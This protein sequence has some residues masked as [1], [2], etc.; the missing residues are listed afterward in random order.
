M[1]D[2]DQGLEEIT[3]DFF[4]ISADPEG[5]IIDYTA[6]SELAVKI[7]VDLSPNIL[8]KRLDEFMATWGIRSQQLTG[9]ME[10]YR[11]ILRRESTQFKTGGDFSF[12]DTHVHLH[13]F[14]QIEGS[15]NIA[16]TV[17]DY[18][19]SH[20]AYLEKDRMVGVLQDIADKLPDQLNNTFVNVGLIVAQ[21]AKLDLGIQGERLIE[22]VQSELSE[23]RGIV[24]RA[25]TDLLSDMHIVMLRKGDLYLYSYVI[26]PVLRRLAQMSMEKQVSADFK[27]SFTPKTVKEDVTIYAER[28]YMLA[29]YERL[30]TNAMKYA[31]PGSSFSFGYEDKGSHHQMNVFS[32]GLSI[33][34]D[35]KEKIFDRYVRLPEA[36]EKDNTGTG[37]GLYVVKKIIE[38]HGGRIWVESDGSSYTN[39]VFTL[40]KQE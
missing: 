4:S 13:F 9:V 7:G 15:G 11:K 6:D 16:L 31:D 24:H 37:Q 36:I 17:F 38:A 10:L 32:Q 21:L 26:K 14:G 40:P 18:T 5:M 30:F 33:P 23:A 2:L 27:H 3:E 20:I 22:V 8:G 25:S 12:D 28:R 35:K 39:F 34:G 1:G 19:V 29:L